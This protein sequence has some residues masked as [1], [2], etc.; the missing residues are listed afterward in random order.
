MKT[1]KTQ[2][3]KEKINSEDK[4]NETYLHSMKIYAIII[5]ERW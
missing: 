1:I 5:K 4:I 3:R 2:K